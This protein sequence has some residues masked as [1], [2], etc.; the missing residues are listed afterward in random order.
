MSIATVKKHFKNLSTYLARDEVGQG[1]LS[2]LKDAVN[3]LRKEAST[4]LKKLEDAEKVKS[5]AIDRERNSADALKSTQQEL[6]RLKQAV[7]SSRRKISALESELER[8]R[9]D[10]RI[11]YASGRLIDDL[12]ARRIHIWAR[13]TGRELGCLP[14][15]KRC[16]VRHPTGYEL[17]DV[18][19][20]FD[21]Q[22]F[23]TLGRT[24]VLKTMLI[25]GAVCI[26]GPHEMEP[27][28][29]IKALSN[30]PGWEKARRMCAG[31]FSKSFS[32]LSDEE[33]LRQFTSG[34]CNWGH[35]HQQEGDTTSALLGDASR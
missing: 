1:M 26:F 25:D 12:T 8:E 32:H 14:K 34:K 7:N 21:D 9:G 22:G 20:A 19:P 2:Q 10:K 29:L 3:G 11:P 33:R 17:H 28:R 24:V 5:G 30:D 6:Q 4:S 35:V 15:P 31:L 23:A 16:E 18:L 27:A 13:R